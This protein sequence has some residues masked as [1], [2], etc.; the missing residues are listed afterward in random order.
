VGIDPEEVATTQH[1]PL[2]VHH[3]A[4]SEDAEARRIR[5]EVILLV[6]PV[7]HPDGQV[8]AVEWYR[9]NLGTAF[10]SAPRPQPFMR[11]PYVGSDTN[12]DLLY[13]LMPESRAVAYQLW[14][15]WYPQI[16]HDHHQ[17]GPFPGRIFVPP[18]TDPMNPNIHPLV[19][20]GVNVVGT[21]LAKRFAEEGKPG[22][23]SHVQYSMWWNGGMRLAPYF[24][25]QIGILTETAGYRHTATPHYYEPDELPDV[26]GPRRGATM[27]AREPSVFYPDPWPGGWWRIGDAVSY[28]VTASLGTAD[29]AARHREDW[30]LNIYR[31]GRQAIEAGEAGGPFAYVVPPEQW[32]ASAAAEMLRVMRRAGLVVHRA[33]AA[34]RADGRRYPAGSYILYGGQAFRPHLL[35]LMERQNYPE[36][37]QWPGGPPDPPYDLAGWTV[38]PAMGVTVERIE[39]PFAAEAE[40]VTQIEPGPARVAADPRWGWALDARQNAAAQAVNRLLA[41]GDRLGRVRGSAG[42]FDDGAFVV[43]AGA[44]THSRLETLAAELGIDVAGLDRQPSGTAWLHPRRVGVYR[45]MVKHNDEGWIRWLL[46]QYDFPWT[47]LLDAQ[48]RAGDLDELDVIVLPNH[49]PAAILNGHATG[50]MPD[51]F[52]GGM[53]TAG[54]EAIR[55]WVEA[56]GT[57]VALAHA[58]DFAID[59]FGLPVRNGVRDVP[60]TQFFVP[61]SLVSI[62]VDTDHSLA[63]GMPAEAT[64]FY[65]NTRGHRSMRFDIIEPARE[66]DRV[67]PPPPVE[68]VVRY[69]DG[70]P[71]VSGYG[72]NSERYLSG[73]AAVVTVALGRG[74]VVL[75]G[76]PPQFRGQTAG[77][78]KLFFNALL[79]AD[80]GVVALSEDDGG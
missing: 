43:Q 66:G 55:R 19:V 69:A 61:A 48:V 58:A 39:E 47:S 56:G 20:R 10:E 17:T 21:H 16:L 14:E 40:P 29:A 34:F 75:F 50:T 65:A 62:L 73:H 4:T 37:Y 30:L 28:M 9:R 41:D 59:Q 36:R 38:P 7:M 80:G 12:R 18:F 76:F 1:V 64:A 51:E 70:D 49:T 45:S 35:D 2:F 74:R 8:K 23:S 78:F 71:L 42:G 67:A 53:G 68:V 5:D 11:H 24:H 79:D 52:T 32:D 77:T 44:G 72:H 13:L 54:A 6:L 3:M 31:M 25:N 27:S 60:E 15:R 57:L 63:A 22:V 46:T 26:L 33:T